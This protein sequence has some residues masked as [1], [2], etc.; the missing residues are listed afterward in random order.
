MI[1]DT[2]RA[3]RLL[4]VACLGLMIM[5]FSALPTVARD[6]PASDK[7]D[8]PSLID[9]IARY[10]AD[11]RDLRSF[12]FIPM[13]P[14]R[15]DRL[16][17]YY[18]R[19]LDEL[20]GLRFD[21][22]EREEQIDYLLL[23]NHAR[24]QLAQI[25]HA[26]TRYQT[27]Q[28]FIP[29]G[30]DVIAL[31]RARWAMEDVNAQQAAATLDALKS[32]VKEA[33]KQIE[34]AYKDRNAAERNAP[35]AD[36]AEAEETP[37]SAESDQ[38]AESEPPTETAG[39]QEPAPE[40][41]PQWHVLTD[42]VQTRRAASAVRSLQR[43]LRSWYSFHAEYRPDFTWWA[44]EPYDA[45]LKEMNDY[46]N[47]LDRKVTDY[48]KKMAAAS[49]NDLEPEDDPATLIGDPI[50]RE[51]LLDELRFEMIPYTPEE[52]LAIGEQQMAWCLNEMNRASAELG[53][54]DWHDALEH[55]K[56][57]HVEPGLQDDLVARQAQGAIDFVDEHEL[58]TVPPLCRETWR[59]KML[60]EQGQKTLPF[61]AYGGQDMLVAYPTIGMNHD[62]KLMSM[63]GNNVHFTRI[64]TP[65]E[66]IPGHHLQGF[67]SDRFKL[68][69]RMFST[70]F[71]GEGWALH[72]EM[73]FWNL[74]YQRS[75][76]D[77][78]GMLFWRMHRAARIVVSLKF[79]L[80][81]MTPTE[82][83]TY[84]E[85]QVGHEHEGAMSEVRRYIGDDYGPLYQCA[86]MIGGLQLTA[87]YQDVVTNSGAMTTRE[88]HD[89]VLE[90]N[91]IPMEMVRAALT[92]EPLTP[93]W[94]P[95]KHIR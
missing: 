38:G 3:P 65:H 42:P 87:L 53:Y 14:Q 4:G 32:Q 35:E 77:R 17:D 37:E 90:Q 25:S 66:L 52:L 86:Y 85:Q 1:T 80:G 47:F 8:T 84:L 27:L 19:V 54:D 94:Q 28:G 93:D 75:P 76:E 82:M 89:A 88:F 5:L 33:R 63:R 81:D 58:V 2:F 34:Q 50:G 78:I 22:L 44:R 79:H 9:V 29:F 12:Y 70:P 40:A 31:E 6:H 45:L 49:D 26:A 57:N 62:K 83:V 56:N 24:R 59:L 55:V 21:Q 36:D 64:V 13:D 46:T 69:R 73:T 30:P 18:Q 74:G 95:Q 67:A 68:H 43:A 91:A 7:A 72:W 23:Q 92:D 61:A 71:Y 60:T 39:L 51:A 48:G 15:W 16:T 41:D 20:D 10:Q 11:H